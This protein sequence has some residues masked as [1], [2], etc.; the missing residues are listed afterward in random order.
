VAVPRFFLRETKNVKD[1]MQWISVKERLPEKPGKKA[2]E[3]VY[4]LVYAPREGSVVRPWNCEHLCWDDESGDDVCNLNEQIT[5]WMPLPDDPGTEHTSEPVSGGT[6]CSL[7][8]D[9]NS[10]QPL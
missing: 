8:E 5:H 3:H 7:S 1:N 2:Y 9:N 10:V 6:P 4:C